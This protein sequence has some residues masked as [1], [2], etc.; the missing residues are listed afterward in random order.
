[1]AKKIGPPNWTAEEINSLGQVPDS[2]L[3]RRSGRTIGDVV[4]MRES[5][6][7][8]LA[9]GP[10]RWTEHEIRLLGTMRDTEISRRLRRDRNDVHRQRVQLKISPF[11]ARPK[12]REWKPREL[13]LLG[14]APDEELA[15]RFKRT[16]ESVAVCRGKLG[17]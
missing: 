1:M 7:V 6:G 10:R 11:K 13:R 2:V 3:A 12:F 5:R 16:V 15:Q 9:T 17:I 4:A 14:T 8:G